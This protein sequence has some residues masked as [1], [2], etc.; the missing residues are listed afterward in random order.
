MY[1]PKTDA[2]IAKYDKENKESIQRFK[3][4]MKKRRTRR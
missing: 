4:K 3:D 2:E 1:R